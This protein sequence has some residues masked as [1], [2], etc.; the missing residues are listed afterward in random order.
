MEHQIVPTGFG[1]M[2][3]SSQLLKLT[4][5]PKKCVSFHALYSAEVDSDAYT[6]VRHIDEE[7]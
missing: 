7:L 6:L 4:L 3:P 2:K 1:M 5:H